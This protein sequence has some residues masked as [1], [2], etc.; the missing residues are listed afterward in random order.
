MRAIWKG[1]ISFALVTI[2]ISL[3]S[4]TDGTSF[5]FITSTKRISARCLTKD[6][7]IPRMSRSRGTRSP[8][9]RV[10]EGAVHR[11]HR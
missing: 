4:A 5:R 7:A 10:R 9:L 6:F 2:P 3:F 8:R 1:H 11:D